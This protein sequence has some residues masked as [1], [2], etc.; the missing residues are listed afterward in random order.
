MFTFTLNFNKSWFI[1]DDDNRVVLEPMEDLTNEYINA[2]YVDVSLQTFMQNTCK[3][4]FCPT[5]GL[6]STKKVH[7]SS[8][9]SLLHSLFVHCMCKTYISWPL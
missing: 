8:R 9:Y 5:L 6:F 2:S 4:V 1:T 7:C 3:H